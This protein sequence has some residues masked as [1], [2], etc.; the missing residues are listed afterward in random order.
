MQIA[1][2]H[3]HLETAKWLY[4]KGRE[5]GAQDKQQQ[6]DGQ[7]APIS[8]SPSIQHREF[9]LGWTALHFAADKGHVDTC[10]WVGDW[11]GVWERPNVTAIERFLDRSRACTCWPPVTSPVLST[12]NQPAHP[13]TNQ[14]A[15]P[16]TNPLTTNLPACLP[17]DGCS[18]KGRIAWH[19]TIG[20]GPL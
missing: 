9:G 2:F 5:Q 15:H 10:R 11:N 1:C 16:P 7:E 14:P 20:A 12:T 3:G 13:P 6:E 17:A 8:S 19:A 18:P 4:K